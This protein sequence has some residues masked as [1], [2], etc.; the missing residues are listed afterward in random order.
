MKAQITGMRE[1]RRG[2]EREGGRVICIFS[3]RKSS[4]YLSPV[5]CFS[6]SLTLLSFLFFVFFPLFSFPCF[7][8]QLRSLSSD[9]AGELDIFGHNGHSLCVNGAEVGVF[10]KT[11]EISLS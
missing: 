11:D 7:L 10:K 8:L 2:E 6:L 4:C 5:R 9:A 1:E 3:F